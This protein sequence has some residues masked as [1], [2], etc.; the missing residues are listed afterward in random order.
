MA[1]TSSLTGFTVPDWPEWPKCGD[2]RH[3]HPVGAGGFGSDRADSCGRYEQML[4]LAF[5][6]TKVETLAQRRQGLHAAGSNTAFIEEIL[7]KA[8]RKRQAVHENL[9]PGQA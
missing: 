3:R 6:V 7:G 8:Q 2:C 4:H 5:L 1:E 9:W